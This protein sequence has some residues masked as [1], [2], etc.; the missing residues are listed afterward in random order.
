[1]SDD[2]PENLS[3]GCYVDHR[4]INPRGPLLKGRALGTHGCVH[5]DGSFE[6]F[7][8]SMV[9][10]PKCA[11]CGTEMDPASSTHWKC[12]DE[13]CDKHEEPIHVGVYPMRS[14]TPTEEP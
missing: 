14:V 3:M 2:K 4:D 1:V 7:S 13:S 12:P 6:F 5:R 10:A 8:V 11:E 9:A